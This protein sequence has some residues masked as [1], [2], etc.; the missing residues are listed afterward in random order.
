MPAIN[1]FDFLKCLHLF[2][3]L[4]LCDKCLHLRYLFYDFI[5]DELQILEKKIN[6]A[7]MPNEVLKVSD[8]YVLVAANYFYS[9]LLTKI[10]SRYQRNYSRLPLLYCLMPMSLYVQPCLALL[11]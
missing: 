2:Y 5:P 9:Q 8:L 10:I 11:S 7:G 4:I 3:D 6:S 1:G